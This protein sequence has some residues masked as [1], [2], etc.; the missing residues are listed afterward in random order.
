MWR[1]P[2]PDPNAD[3]NPD[4]N[5]DPYADPHPDPNADP[6]ADPT[7][8]STLFL[9]DLSLP[10]P[11]LSLTNPEPNP[12]PIARQPTH[13]LCASRQADGLSALDRGLAIGSPRSGYRVEC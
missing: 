7:L 9:R 6:N 2:N 13:A 3:P 10:Q 11:N 1:Y 5:H 4:T 8:I 12:N